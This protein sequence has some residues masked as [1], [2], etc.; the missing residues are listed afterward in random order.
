[1][2]R[3]A[4]YHI[5]IK[6]W[7]LMQRSKAWKMRVGDQLE[8]DMGKENDRSFISTLSVHY[9]RICSKLRLLVSSAEFCLYSSARR[10]PTGEISVII[11]TRI[12]ITL[13]TPSPQLI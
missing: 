6:L 3:F 13:Y 1:M 12:L 11:V 4:R 7:R 9:I 5:L 10:K 2:M 8:E